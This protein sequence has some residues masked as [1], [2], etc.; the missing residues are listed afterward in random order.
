LDSLYVWCFTAVPSISYGIQSNSGIVKLALIVGDHLLQN[1]SKMLL[2]CLAI[3]K[4]TPLHQ[5]K[6]KETLHNSVLIS[7][8]APWNRCQY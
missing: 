4:K 7:P 5:K 6:K 2:R 8:K 3:K 1:W